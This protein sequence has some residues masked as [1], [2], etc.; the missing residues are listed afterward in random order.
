MLSQHPIPHFA[1]IGHWTMAYLFAFRHHTALDG[2][3]QATLFVN[4]SKI[5]HGQTPD[6]HAPYKEFV[7]HCGNVNQ[8]MARDFRASQFTGRR[9]PFPQ[10]CRFIPGSSSK[11]ICAACRRNPRSAPIIQ[12]PTWTLGA[13]AR[14]SSCPRQLSGSSSVWTLH[15][16]AAS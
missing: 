14:R 10:P 7:R 9:L 16:L 13:L 2:F 8:T 1:T 12:R 3:G 4:I 15:A 5:Y 6:P 11:R